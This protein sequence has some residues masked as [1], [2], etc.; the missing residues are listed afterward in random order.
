MEKVIAQ[1]MSNVRN[2]L[3]LMVHEYYNEDGDK[4]GIL[5]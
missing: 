3:Q 4:Q 5:W 2:N 1:Q